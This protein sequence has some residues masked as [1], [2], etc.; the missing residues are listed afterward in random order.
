MTLT[1]QNMRDNVRRT[2]GVNS[3]D[4][5]DPVIDEYINKSYWEIDETYPFKEKDTFYPLTTVTGTETYTLDTGIEAIADVSILNPST[6]EYEVLDR[7]SEVWWAS[8]RSDDQGFPTRYF[9]SSNQITLWMIPDDVYAIVINATKQLADLITSSQSPDMPRAWH[10]IVEMGAK[11]RAMIDL[12]DL[13]RSNQIRNHQNALISNKVPVEAKEE[14]DSHR[15]GV[16]VPGRE[17]TR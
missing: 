4:W 15:A 16:E 13:T 14:F 9:R 8:E 5:P 10:E 1:L 3:T 7:M 2:M 11:W 6:N 12:G 17:Y